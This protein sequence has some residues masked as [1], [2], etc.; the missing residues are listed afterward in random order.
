MPYSGPAGRRF[1]TSHSDQSSLGAGES[2]PRPQSEG[3]SALRS[4]FP[5]NKPARIVEARLTSL[6]GLRGVAAVIVVCFHFACAF[7]ADIVPGVAAKPYWL[8]D[9]PLGLFWNGP[10]S[11]SVFFVLSGFV[12]ANAAAKRRSP[13]YVNITLRYF[14]LAIPA[15]CS[16]VFAW[17]LLKLFPDAATDVNRIQPTIWLEHTYQAGD[18]PG[19]LH[20]IAHGLIGIYVSAGSKFNNVLWTMLYELRGSVGLYLCY[21]LLSG[22][23]RRVVLISI[24]ALSLIGISAPAYVSFVFGALLRDLWAAGHR[25]FFPS[26]ALLGGALIGFPAVGFADRMG[27][28]G[29]PTVL[30]LGDP[31]SIFAAIA[32]AMIVYGTLYSSFGKHFSGRICQFFGTISFP[33]YL[34]HVPLIC[35]VFAA[36]YAMLAPLTE[37][38]LPAMFAVFLAASVAMAWGA[39]KA[40]DSP[41]LSALSTIRSRFSQLKRNR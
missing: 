28:G 17:A 30:A 23:A 12:V 27:F 33:L 39:E 15:L 19:F 25:P 41:T 34:I 20:M 32:A 14:R 37:A 29:A 24:G 9:T 18:L 5:D 10:F 11:V 22:R 21:G 40:I 8:A 16:V 38:G 2:P 36:V 7:R 1:D 6:D 13:V 3:R 4:R 31:D 26:V 35:T